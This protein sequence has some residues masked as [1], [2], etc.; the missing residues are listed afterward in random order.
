MKKYKVLIIGMGLVLLLAPF[1]LFS[2]E[3]A[4]LL[5][6]QTELTAQGFST[7][8]IAQIMTEA[9]N[10]NWEDLDHE[11]AELAALSLK[12]CQRSRMRLHIQEQVELA[13]H[14]SAMGAEMKN[15]GFKAQH[16][17]R[18][19]LNTTRQYIDSLQLQN[20][21]RDRLRT[22][23]MIRERIRD[24]LCKEG[25]TEQEEKLM[26][27]LHVRV[28]NSMREQNHNRDIGPKF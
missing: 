22:R 27:R 23:D 10:M 5:R 1:S 16:I 7:Q 19:A 9:Q 4:F 11:F 20:Q 18:F 24:E 3:Q 8:E 2:Q 6:L 28:R 12:L 21:D 13:Y 17:L 14:L 25:L 15:L 26:Q